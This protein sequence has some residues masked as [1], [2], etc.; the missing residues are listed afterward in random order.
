MKK[1]FF[2]CDFC[3]YKA[4]QRTGLRRHVESMHMNI[5]H[6]C[7]FCDFQSSTK[8]AVKRHTLGFHMDKVKI[9]ECSKCSFRSQFKSLLNKHLLSK[10]N[11][12]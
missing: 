6:L 12:H 5:K 10:D 8:C 9:F 2:E 3:E 1:I 4:S 11:K 7:D